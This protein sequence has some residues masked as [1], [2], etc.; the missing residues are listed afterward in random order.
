LST[1]GEFDV[2]L[3]AQYWGNITLLEELT[4]E[5]LS[6]SIAPLCDLNPNL[7][8][9]SILFGRNED[10]APIC[11]LQ[12][13]T[14][15]QVF[16][17]D[18]PGAL[19]IELSKQTPIPPL[20]MLLMSSESSSDPDVLVGETYRALTAF[21]STLSWL[22]LNFWGPQVYDEK[23][24]VESLSQ[25]TKL[26]TFVLQWGGSVESFATIL[27]PMKEMVTVT[28]NPFQSSSK[29]V[30]I[31]PIFEALSGMPQLNSVAFLNC[32][33][34]QNSDFLHLDRN[35]QLRSLNFTGVN[36]LGDDAIKFIETVRSLT[37]YSSLYVGG[38]SM[39]HEG[40]AHLQ[41][42]LRLLVC[43]IK[44]QEAP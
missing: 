29:A 2:N 25:L 8:S 41:E 1:S 26:T 24:V 42:N 28:I 39:S 9:I 35:F 4:I 22:E 44:N 19:I 37:S 12:K 5:N 27:A 6:N 43:D 30:S 7:S 38:E 14:S 32:Y 34:I 13:L 18:R 21:S 40:K 23:L 15:L 10:I 11:K 31:T 36:G 33:G 3:A 16:T 17:V 20:S